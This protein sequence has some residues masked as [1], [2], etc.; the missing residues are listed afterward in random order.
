M[1]PTGE[2]SLGI[3]WKWG[4]TLLA[5]VSLN[6]SERSRRRITCMC[7]EDGVDIHGSP[8]WAVL[9]VSDQFK[10]LYL[11]MPLGQPGEISFSW[12]SSSSFIFSSRMI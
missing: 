12:P 2:R 7:R 3:E 6:G 11:S 4:R 5:A 1:P 10:R 9:G 8:S